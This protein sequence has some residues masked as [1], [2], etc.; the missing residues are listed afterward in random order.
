[1]LIVGLTG[2]IG[3]GKSTVA[4]MFAQLGALTIDADQLARQAIEPGSS[5]F[6]EVVAAFG[7]EI[8][9]DGD[10]DRQK[11][12]KIVFK[13]A[14]KRKQLE[15]IVHPRVQEALAA[16]IKTL[17]PGDIL[18]YEIPLLVESGAADRFDYIITVESDIENRLDR[19][20]ERGLDED[21]AERRI[22]AQAT[23]A[24]REAVA[25]RVIINDGVRADLFAECARIWEAELNAPR[26]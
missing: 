2:G 21:E 5:G 7:E 25:N 1:M 16:K 20:F 12:G 9:A 24:Q 6:D 4:N 14:A 19:L 10:I 11:L 3:A 18:I 26:Q 13:D 22:A 15:A 17:S 8:V 23:P